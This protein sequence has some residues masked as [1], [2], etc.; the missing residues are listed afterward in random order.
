MYAAPDENG[1]LRIYS[2]LERYGAGQVGAV[3]TEPAVEAKRR[4]F[5]PCAADC[6]LD[7][8]GRLLLAERMARHASL[9]KEV[10]SLGVH[11]H[12]RLWDPQRLGE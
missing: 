9:Y 2:E 8:Q 12:L 10:I 7:G 5:F 3:W 6:Q 1:C 4:P 11:Y